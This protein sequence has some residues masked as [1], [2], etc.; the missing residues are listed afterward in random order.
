MPSFLSG[1]LRGAIGQPAFF[2]AENRM[3]IVAFEKEASLI[4]T[5][6]F[7]LRKNI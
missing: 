3:T 2:L 4:S 6:V 1:K 5:E 7:N